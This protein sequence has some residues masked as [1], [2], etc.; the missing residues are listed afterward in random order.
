MSS[1]DDCEAAAEQLWPFLD[2]ALPETQRE[3]VVQHLESCTNC[4][5]HLDFAR[6]FL[7]AV[8]EVSRS[9]SEFDTVRARVL[10]AL[11]AEGFAAPV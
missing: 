8:H 1:R 4:T 2:G 9:E 11:A 5:S 3:H 7:E 10:S 6:A